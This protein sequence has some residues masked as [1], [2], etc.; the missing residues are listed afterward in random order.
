MMV[1]DKIHVYFVELASLVDVVDF[2]LQFNGKLLAALRSDD[3]YRIEILAENASVPVLRATES[4]LAYYTL[5][6]VHS[7]QGEEVAAEDLQRAVGLFPDCLGGRWN[8]MYIGKNK[9]LASEF[10]IKTGNGF[11]FN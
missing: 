1:D 5:H 4:F 7:I 6:A 9:K 10:G 2:N 8:W 3:V 11:G